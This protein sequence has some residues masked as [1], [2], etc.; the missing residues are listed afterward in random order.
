M[1]LVQPASP[2]GLFLH[3]FEQLIF[4]ACIPP[5]RLNLNIHVLKND[6]WIFV[7]RMLLNVSKA[8]CTTE[9][10][11]L[12]GFI[13]ISA[14]GHEPCLLD[15][16]TSL[17]CDYALMIYLAVAVGG[18]TSL[19]NTFSCAG[20]SSPCVCWGGYGGLT[21]TRKVPE[22]ETMESSGAG[23]APDGD[24]RPFL[25]PQ[26]RPP[27]WAYLHKAITAMA[28]GCLTSATGGL[29]YLLRWVGVM[30]ASTSVASACVSMG[31]VLVLTGL[32]WIPVLREK[33]RRKLQSD[34]E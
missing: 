28:I 14:P 27:G 22:P 5:A 17:L 7:P 30:E 26:Q 34:W 4:L 29:L 31:L 10:Q 6:L 13:H 2:H 16:M 25:D 24:G 8:A 23:S 18:I 9:P 15:H 3:V 1:I 11:H 33:Q 12:L 32:L 20:G 21:H 19:I